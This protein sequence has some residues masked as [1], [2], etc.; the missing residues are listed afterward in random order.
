MKRRMKNYFKALEDEL[1]EALP[2]LSEKLRS[3]PLPSAEQQPAQRRAQNRRRRWLPVLSTAAAAFLL[4]A[5][6]LPMLLLHSSPERG[7]S[8]VEFQLNPVIYLATDPDDRVTALSSGNEDGDILLSD[9]AFSA[10]LLGTTAS[11]AVKSLALC[12]EELGYLSAGKT[13]RLTV[14]SDSA[15]QAERLA[16]DLNRSL[17]SVTAEADAS[18]YAVV[19]T[20]AELGSQTGSSAE[21]AKELIE[22][23]FSLPVLLI[24]RE[25]LGVTEENFLEYY[26]N[27][28][29][30][31]A[32][33]LV[34][35]TY[36][37]MAE[38]KALLN[39]IEDCN[40]RI[41]NHED[42]PGLLIGRDYWAIADRTDLSPDLLRETEQMDALLAR[43][44]TAFDQTLDSA[45]FYLLHGWYSLLNL[46]R[47]Q[48]RMEDLVE[49]LSSRLI[50]ISEMIDSFLSTI[51]TD[52]TLE[53]KISDCF[54][55][56]SSLPETK[57]QC[58]ND[59]RTMCE[60]YREW[61]SARYS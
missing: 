11:E 46:E 39:L 4:L 38:K 52:E 17:S 27:A 5:V 48:E 18:A 31:Y 12:S 19:Q 14:A 16:D 22:H 43:Y 3:A 9:P 57:E 30:A 36:G 29:S 40:E 1:D 50:G 33:R 61:L 49:R 23:I 13:I 59:A 6:S 2:P 47:Q 20:P 32:S 37:V 41:K 10:S 42:N 60:R 7:E 15:A 56:F 53:S 54:A 26:L 35:Q 25:A 34:A 8:V 58:L 28:F 55:P 24:E 51:T 21:T 45:S 44:R